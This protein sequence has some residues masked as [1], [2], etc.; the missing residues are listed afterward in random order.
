MIKYGAIQPETVPQWCRTRQCADILGIAECTLR[1]RKSRGI[2][3]QGEHW[4]FIGENR[5]G[6]ILWN[7]AAC[8]QA[9]HEHV[10]GVQ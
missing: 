7:P 5:Q 6:G 3:K 8:L 10:M 2:L 4:F 1:R 9:M